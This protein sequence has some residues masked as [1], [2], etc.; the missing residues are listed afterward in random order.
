MLLFPGPQPVSIERRNFAQLRAKPY[1]YCEK[2]DGTRYVLV[3]ETDKAVLLDRALKRIPAGV[4][5]PHNTMLD[6]ELVKTKEGKNIFLVFDA[7]KLR[8]VD[9]T[10]ENLTQRLKLAQEL[11]KS[12]I[13]V[14]TAPFEIRVKNMYS[15]VAAMPPM[16]TLQWETDGVVMTP[17]NEPV[18]HGTHETMFKWKPMDR[19]TID[20][21]YKDSELWIQNRRQVELSEP[22][23]FK[24][25]DIVECG[26]SNGW[27]PI[28]AR[29]DKRHPNN[30]RTF[31]RT[32]V[33]LREAIRFSEL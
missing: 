23:P 19:I 24:N 30:A 25:G 21:L 13:K 33:N 4:R 20:F 15:S 29:T 22:W 6:G 27:F 12:I 17:V 7:F 2:T 28:K 5:I 16:E 1:L 10:Q 14:K 32:L 11:V 3:C 18:R 8:G 31:D 26:Y 9:V